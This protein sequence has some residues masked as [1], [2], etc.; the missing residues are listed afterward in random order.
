MSAAR[1]LDH[2][3]PWLAWGAVAS[4]GIY[5]PSELL[6][7]AIPLLLAALVEWRRW[8]LS[9]YRRLLEILALV[10]LLAMA[11]TRIGLVPIVVQVVFFLCGVRLALPR[12][13]AQR[14][15]VLLMGFLI[16]LTTA[17]TSFTLD[18]CF[19]SLAWVAG[20]A[21]VLLPQSWEQ[22]E[23]THRAQRERPPFGKILKWSLA[24]SLVA[25]SV[26][27][28]MPRISRRFI[29]WSIAGMG[30]ARAGLADSLELGESGPI[31]QNRD[32]ALR[33][34][35]TRE[36]TS[37][38]RARWAEHLSLLRGL[39]LEHLE[40]LTWK[41]LGETPSFR[42]VSTPRGETFEF[43]V[44]PNVDALIPVPYGRIMLSPP[45]GMPLWRGRGGSMRWAFPTR[46]SL[47]LQVHVEPSVRLEEGPPNRL[48]WITLTQTSE[49][50]RCAERWSRS[51]V[52]GDLPPTEL[53]NRLSA[54]LQGFRYTLDNPSGGAA[55]PMEDFLEHSRAGHCEYFASALALMLRYRGI[56]ARVVNGY[57]RGPWNP[58]GGYWLVTQNEAHSWVEYFDRTS[59]SW[60]V[61]DP[62]PAAPE[63][64]GTSASL[65]EGL[66]RWL[67]ALSYRWDRYVVRFSDQD[68]QE[69]FEWLR[70][71]L[72][73]VRRWRFDWRSPAMLTLG[74]AL[75]LLLGVGLWLRWKPVRLQKGA[76]GL[77]ALRPLLRATRKSHP[78]KPEE[79][80]RLW[81]M[82]LA[83]AR[84]DRKP[85]LLV[86]A[87]AAEAEAY[88]GRAPGQA[89]ALARRE[90][91][92]WRTGSR[93]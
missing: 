13:L 30:G 44:A 15:Q 84:P 88:G 53:A 63:A 85:E 82:R 2:L 89:L 8:S 39:V 25:G 87:E 71:K 41:P 36:L 14:R 31:Q 91:K 10:F 69:G 81:L 21:L 78:P 11:W 26:F 27:L 74:Y 76:Q 1:W 35:P 73:R 64:E 47:S 52:P 29:P 55:N 19:W 70:E 90:A 79:T 16:W 37:A 49:A 56:P 3:P 6:L 46:T 58:D 77:S 22:S 57:R 93:P 48:R 45:Q 20:T 38:E 7:M 18:F 5:G 24:T 17:V 50:S 51:V 60:Q 72:V 23:G 9:R 40:G 33:I 66:T 86:L 43:F 68:Q 12:T 75:L 32:V 65:W 61:A 59:R 62:T 80:L 83:Q 28:V 54:R 42:E 34:V 4:T 92:A 67:D